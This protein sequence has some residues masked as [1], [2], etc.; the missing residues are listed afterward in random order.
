MFLLS[1]KM[2]CFSN[3]YYIYDIDYE[4]SNIEL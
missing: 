3:I 2:I 4:K 1:W